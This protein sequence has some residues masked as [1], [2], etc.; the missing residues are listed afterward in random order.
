[1][2]IA[3]ANCI[4]NVFEGVL[5]NRLEEFLWT[6]ENQFGFKLGHVTDMSVDIL[7]E[8]IDSYRQISTIKGLL[9]F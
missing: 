9:Y 6:C 8:I 3:I 1:M 5:L 2:S 4:S 7:R